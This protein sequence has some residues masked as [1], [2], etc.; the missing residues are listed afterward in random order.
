MIFE[1]RVKLATD[2]KTLKQVAIKILKVGKEHL[3]YSSKEEALRCLHSEANI[4]QTCTE[5]KIQGVIK[6]KD[7]SFDGTLVK[8]LCDDY[9]NSDDEENSSAK[10]GRQLK[11]LRLS[12][13]SSEESR[14]LKR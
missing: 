2:L 6:I 10:V 1:D 11:K 12:E 9:S 14:I 4:L 7:C 5:R 3:A 8:E 13:N